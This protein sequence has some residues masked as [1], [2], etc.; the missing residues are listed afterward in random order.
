[1]YQD[2]GVNEL[3]TVCN[4]TFKGMELAGQFTKTTAKVF[5]R[6]CTFIM[7]GSQWAINKMNDHQ[8]AKSGKKSQKIL[9]DKYQ[10][11]VLYGRFESARETVKKQEAENKNF[12]EDQLSRLP[13]AKWQEKRFGQLAKKHGLEY[14]VMSNKSGNEDVFFIQYPK[15]QEHIFQEV[16]AEL[17][18]EIKK[19]CEKAFH[20][21]DKENEKKCEVEVNTCKEQISNKKSELE[22]AKSDLKTHHKIGDKVGEKKYAEIIVVLQ[23]EIEQL[24]EKL[25]GLMEKWNTVRAQT[26][27]DLIE[28][29]TEESKEVVKGK[30]VRQI[31]PLQYLEQSGLLNASEQE[32]S[33][34]MMKVFP[35]EYE[36]VK[37]AIEQNVNS[38]QEEYLSD[39]KLQKK[40]KEFVRRM[41][42]N[43][44]VAAKENGSV[45]D[46]DIKAAD[47]VK[48]SEKTASFPHPEYPE[49]MIT[50]STKN[51]C[52]MVDDSGV[53]RKKNGQVEGSINMS[54][55]K[56]SKLEFEVPVLDAVT[57]KCVQDKNGKPEFVKMKMTYEEFDKHIKDIGAVAAVAMKKKQVELNQAMKLAE[58]VA[59]MKQK[60][61][62]NAKK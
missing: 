2:N 54:V 23:N 57:G 25:T 20:E 6:I 62:P 58:K 21:I 53:R 17:Q 29:L 55:Y 51:I 52:G 36:E 12:S 5:L 11:D 38:K 43:V 37:K 33:E 26:G 7:T 28:T 42:K 13:D 35:K 41:N 27:Q 49:F 30:V 32:F 61:V 3:A 15:A 8:Y 9:R 45:I 59:A 16:N 31:T 19:E 56:E 4:V 50:I 34:E 47:Y 24:K 60:G 1:M 10:G 40:K 48:R 14:C 44:R 22:Q 39:T 46:F 18:T